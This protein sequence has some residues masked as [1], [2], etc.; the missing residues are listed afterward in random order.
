MNSEIT[1]F[2]E[3]LKKVAETSGGAKGLSGLSEIPY[4]TLHGYISGKTEPRASEIATI[5][6][7]TGVDL[8]W[9]VAGQ[10]E[11]KQGGAENPE[12]STPDSTQALDVDAA[13]EAATAL[14]REIAVVIYQLMGELKIYKQCT[15]QRFNRLIELAINIEAEARSEAAKAGLPPPPIS[16][17]RYRQILKATT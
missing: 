14:T 12:K 16:I 4:T 15:P 8:R 6:A 5:A 7:V 11:M 9:L 10:G 2:A 3:R 17:D 1:S 13:V